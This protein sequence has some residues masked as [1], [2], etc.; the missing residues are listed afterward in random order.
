[1]IN[2]G[3]YPS[4]VNVIREFALSQDS[5][6]TTI[7]LSEDGTEK[8][9]DFMDAMEKVMCALPP[10]ARVD[11][12]ESLAHNSN[13]PPTK[14]DNG[15]KDGEATMQF[16]EQSVDLLDDERIDK[17]LARAGIKAAN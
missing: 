16:G 15:P 1:L 8:S 6:G 12:S 17:M 4:A 13:P 10:E 14:P 3:H 5:V 11:M 9:Y 7:K 2:D